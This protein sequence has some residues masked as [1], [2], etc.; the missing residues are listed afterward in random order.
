MDALLE[1]WRINDRINRYLLDAIPPDALATPL[2]KGKSVAA[3]LSQFQKSSL[4]FF[5]GSG[6][7]LFCENRFK[8]D[9]TGYEDSIV[10][11]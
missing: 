5:V 3:N 11:E 1:T 10:L 9:R 8:R 4:A 7:S 2:A 6:A